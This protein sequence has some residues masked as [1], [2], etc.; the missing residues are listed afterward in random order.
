MNYILE[1]TEW[2]KIFD[3]ILN[4]TFSHIKNAGREEFSYVINERFY[5]HQ[6]SNYLYQ[7]FISKDIN[8]WEKQ[9]LFPEAKTNEVFT[10]KNININNSAETK[11]GAIGRGTKGNFD[12]RI[13]STPPIYLE[14]KGPNMY[15]VVDIVQVALKLFS[16]PNE[17]TIKILS[18]IITSSKTGNQRHLKTIYNHFKE[19]LEFALK[20]L[21]INHISN[22]KFYVYIATISDNSIVKC[23]WGPFNDL[24]TKFEYVET[25]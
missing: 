17:E 21:N 23:H 1:K 20:V 15:S 6:F 25:K 5:H 2:E 16:N 12:F 8:I 24:E 22:K 4:N 3:T 11:E 9:I 14:W 7:H 18:A 19:G 10:W 13:N